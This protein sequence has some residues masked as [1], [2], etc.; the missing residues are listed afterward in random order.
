ALPVRD[1]RSV[2]VNLE[3][4]R[5]ALE[6][7]LVAAEEEEPVAA[8]GHEPRQGAAHSL[9]GAEEGDSHGASP[10]RRTDCALR[11][12]P[13]GSHLRRTALNA[14]MRGPSMARKCSARVKPSLARYTRPPSAM[15]NSFSAS[16]TRRVSGPTGMSSAYE[17]P[18]RG[19]E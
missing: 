12:R 18:R 11:N 6:V 9:G 3:V 2:A 17:T 19:K 16:T 4:L 1:R 8:R 15:T 7:A 10:S 14:S 5:A 13:P